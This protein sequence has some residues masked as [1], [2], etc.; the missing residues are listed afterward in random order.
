MDKSVKDTLESPTIKGLIILTGLILM[1]CAIYTWVEKNANAAG[2][3]LS[4]F[5]CILISGLIYFYFKEKASSVV[6]ASLVS[7]LTSSSSP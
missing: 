5:G 3:S 4:A 1:G 6:A 7:S 2:T